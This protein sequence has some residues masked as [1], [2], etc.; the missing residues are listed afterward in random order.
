[1]K[2]KPREANIKLF[3]LPLAVKIFKN[4]IALQKWNFLEIWNLC[5]MER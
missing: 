5:S 2:F 4:G 1:M 3:G